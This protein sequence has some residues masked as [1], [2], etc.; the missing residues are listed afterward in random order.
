MN[1]PGNRFIAT[2]ASL[3][4]AALLLATW[5]SGGLTS[6]RAGAQPAEAPSTPAESRQSALAA[7]A[8]GKADA[9]PAIQQLVD[10]GIGRIR[11]PK[12]TYRITKPIV[13]D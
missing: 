11:L 12:G 7:V 10:S 1:R 3:A 4:M 9:T 2:L 8:D 5:L 13:V 6:Q